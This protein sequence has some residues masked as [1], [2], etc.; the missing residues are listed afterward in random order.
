MSIY[1]RIQ[2]FGSSAPQLLIIH[3]AFLSKSWHHCR[4]IYTK[5]H[6]NSFSAC[7]KSEL[8]H[9][10]VHF[11][12]EK[13]WLIHEICIWLS[14]AIIFSL[15]KILINAIIDSSLRIKQNAKS[16]LLLDLNSLGCLVVLWSHFFRSLKEEY[17]R[18][19]HGLIM[20]NL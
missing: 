16:W 2:K 4:K 6:L 10:R 12:V 5:D 11:L 1:K 9:I 14:N 7:W 20:R 3:G 15:Q 17:W 13:I 8:S 19:L 18:W